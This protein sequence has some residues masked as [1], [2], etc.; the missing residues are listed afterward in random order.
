MNGVL[1]VP[2][3]L[4]SALWNIISNGVEAILSSEEEG[5]LTV[6]ATNYLDG[7]GA[8][9]VR[10]EVKDSGNGIPQEDSHKIFTPFF[11]TKGRGRGYGLWRAK[12]VID[13]L[14]GSI[15]VDC[16]TDSGAAFHIILPSAPEEK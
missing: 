4:A 3:S 12:T 14:G 1:A 2:S 8:K 16:Q 6:N 15:S 11:T 7:Q 10:I 9:W 5:T 13:S